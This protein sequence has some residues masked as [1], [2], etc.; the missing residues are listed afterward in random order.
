MAASGGVQSRDRVGT[1]STSEPSLELSCT[2][3]TLWFPHTPSWRNP[4]HPQVHLHDRPSVLTIAT[5]FDLP[6]FRRNGTSDMTH[7]VAMSGDGGR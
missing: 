2:L 7:P 1:P 3:K 4:N 6:L 5:K